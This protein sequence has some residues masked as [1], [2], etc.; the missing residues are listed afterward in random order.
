LVTGHT[1]SSPIRTVRFPSNWNLSQERADVVRGML[2][3]RLAAPTRVRAEGRADTEPV[4]ANDVAENKARNRR[5]EVMLLV[6]PNVP[7]QAL[8]TPGATT[9]P[10]PGAALPSA[11]ARK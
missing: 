6:A 4:A 9:P 1:D 3:A 10:A 11:P 7:E 2:A 5:V 8:P